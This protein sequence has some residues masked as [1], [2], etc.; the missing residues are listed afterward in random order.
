MRLI[1]NLSDEKSAAE[2]STTEGKMHQDR[3][4]HKHEEHHPKTKISILKNTHTDFTIGLPLKKW[5]KETKL[6][7]FV[8]WNKQGM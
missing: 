4:T 7:L 3:I 5:G 6:M 8:S 1:S 2:I